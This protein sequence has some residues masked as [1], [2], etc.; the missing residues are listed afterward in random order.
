M[1]TETPSVT[2]TVPSSIPQ[3]PSVTQTAS[4]PPPTASAVVWPAVGGAHAR[5]PAWNSLSRIV[6]LILAILSAIVLVAYRPV[7]WLIDRRRKLRTMTPVS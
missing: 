3:T 7:E 6:P 4:P 5:D 1:A 2:E